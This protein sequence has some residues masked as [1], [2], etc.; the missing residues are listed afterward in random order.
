[1][2]LIKMRHPATMQQS[3]GWALGYLV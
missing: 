3:L 1:M 2:V